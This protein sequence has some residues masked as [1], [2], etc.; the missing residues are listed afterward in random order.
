MLLPVPL[1]RCSVKVPLLPFLFLFRIQ[2]MQFIHLARFATIELQQQPAPKT[3]QGPYSTVAAPSSRRAC[4]QGPMN[5]FLIFALLQRGSASCGRVARLRPQF[6]AVSCCL[7][8]C[9]SLALCHSICSNRISNV[10][11]IVVFD[12]AADSL[13]SSLPFLSTDTEILSLSLNYIQ[14]AIIIINSNLFKITPGL[15]ST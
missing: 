8:T 12:A 4:P 6:R 15:E 9:N 10:A 14:R 13:S 2:P 7:A 11:V 5:A 3:L 1:A